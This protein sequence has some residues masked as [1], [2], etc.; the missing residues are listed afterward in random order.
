MVLNLTVYDGNVIFFFYKQAK[1][2]KIPI[3]RTF[4]GQKKSIL[5]F[6]LL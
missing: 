5:A 4:F 2:G 3:F 6:I 1:P